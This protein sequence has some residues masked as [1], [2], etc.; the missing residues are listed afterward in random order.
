[1]PITE[2]TLLLTALNPNLL[3]YSH[4]KFFPQVIDHE[5]NN[6]HSL[7][8]GLCSLQLWTVVTTGGLGPIGLVGLGL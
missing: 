5:N 3:R 7:G 2:S 1:M 8:L 4:P 6:K